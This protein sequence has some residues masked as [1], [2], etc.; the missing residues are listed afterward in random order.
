M[1][2]YRINDISSTV[3]SVTVMLFVQQ[4]LP[5][6]TD[7]EAHHREVRQWT[8]QILPVV[9]SCSY[10]HSQWLEPIFAM[11]RIFAYMDAHF[12]Q[13][14]LQKGQRKLQGKFSLSTS[15]QTAEAVTPVQTGTT[16]QSRGEDGCCGRFLICTKQPTTEIHFCHLSPC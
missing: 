13:F 5:E 16:L 11:V 12:A 7:T 4:V 2:Q 6:T 9:Q 1:S 8:N 3:D 14:L 10:C 15:M